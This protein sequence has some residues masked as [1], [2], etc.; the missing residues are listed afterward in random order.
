MRIFCCFELFF[1]LVL[2][3]I[4]LYLNASKMCVKSVSDTSKVCQ[5][6]VK[7]SGR[8]VHQFLKFVMHY[9]DLLRAFLYDYKKFV[10]GSRIKMPECIIL[11]KNL[12]MIRDRM[13]ISQIELAAEC[14]IST[15]TLSLLEREQTDP[16]LSTIQKIA[17]YL[18]CGVADLLTQNEQKN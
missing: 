17:S 18:G 13:D 3:C 4:T 11:S 12:K 2:F 5:N 10:E 15:E 6:C 1:L 8:N 14:G 16:K 7:I 9:L